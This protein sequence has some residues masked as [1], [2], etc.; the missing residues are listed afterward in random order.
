MGSAFETTASCVLVTAVGASAYRSRPG[1]WPRHPVELA[2]YDALWT[3]LQAC[4]ADV[5]VP[6]AAPC[7]YAATHR[8][9][10]RG[11]TGASSSARASG[12]GG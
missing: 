10:P 8:S 11:A 12:S 5:A 6:I 9:Q 7:G 3:R 4:T 2:G 1:G